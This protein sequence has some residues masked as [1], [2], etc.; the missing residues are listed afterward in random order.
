MGDCQCKISD[1]YNQNSS[2]E[3]SYENFSLK[4]YTVL[5]STTLDS[6]HADIMDRTRSK[7]SGDLDTL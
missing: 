2:V 5:Q 4:K 6:R 7:L 3:G 1:L